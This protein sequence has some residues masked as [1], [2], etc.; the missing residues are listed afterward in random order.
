[1]IEMSY[2]LVKIRSQT[3]VLQ[4]LLKVSLDVVSVRAWG[5]IIPNIDS[6]VYVVC[7]IVVVHHGAEYGE[8]ALAVKSVV[9]KYV[10]VC[11][12]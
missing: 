9:A 5:T 11:K 4:R 8:T 1:M 3:F 2:A 10:G 7:G 12:E 6:L